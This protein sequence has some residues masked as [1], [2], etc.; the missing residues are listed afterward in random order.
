MA[1]IPITSA[2][3]LRDISGDATSAR[4]GEF[5]VRY[6]PMM[7]AFLRERFPHLEADDVIQE[8]LI[9]LVAKLPTYRYV[10]QETGFFHNYLTGILR[11]KALR[12]CA[13]DKR[14]GEVMENYRQEPMPANPE[15][16]R[17][18]K[19]WRESV[20]EIALQQVLADETIHGRTRQIFVRTAIN[21]EKPEQVAESLGIARNAVDQAKNRMINRLRDIVAQLEA[22]DAG[23]G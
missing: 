8:T 1:D 10:P 6:R 18:E 13:R 2:T 22:V 11:R 20:Y 23:V 7:E 14:R 15:Q 21:N 3:L 5:V 16:E 9:A 4:W 12:V 17:E 19:A